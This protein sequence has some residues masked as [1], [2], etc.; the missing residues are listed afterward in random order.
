MEGARHRP[1]YLPLDSFGNSINSNLT[2]NTKTC[3]SYS[4]NNIRGTFVCVSTGGGAKLL[5]AVYGADN[6]FNMLER[7]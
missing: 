4:R 3:G 5:E 7:L 6:L 2:T 1:T